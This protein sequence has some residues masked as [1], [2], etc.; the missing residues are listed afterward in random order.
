LVSSRLISLRE[1]SF[2]LDSPHLS[3]CAEESQCT[4]DRS[5][6]MHEHPYKNIKYVKVGVASI[7]Q[8]TN[9]KMTK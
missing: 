5:T 6:V 1:G 3:F 2:G 7:I 9:N 8:P 4:A